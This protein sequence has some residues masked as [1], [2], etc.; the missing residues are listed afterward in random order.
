MKF[1]S[2]S[3]FVGPGF[4][5]MNP[6]VSGFAAIDQSMDPAFFFQFLDP[7][8]NQLRPTH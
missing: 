4:R 6:H 1:S 7:P 8:K 5:K 3:K 2:E